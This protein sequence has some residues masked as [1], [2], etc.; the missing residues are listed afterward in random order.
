MKKLILF[1]IGLMAV[2]TPRVTAAV[3]ADFFVRPEATVLLPLTDTDTRLDMIEYFKAGAIPTRTFPEGSDASTLRI[4]ALND[5]SM[6]VASK[7]I[8]VDIALFVEPAKA[9][10]LV[11]ATTTF[12]VAGR[13]DSEISVFDAAL[14]PVTTLRVPVYTDWIVPEARKTAGRRLL[15]SVPFI[16]ARAVA[17]P[18]ALTVTFVNTTDLRQSDDP[19]IY[20]PSITYRLE[21]RR[22]K[23][24]KAA[25]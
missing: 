13:E 14:N 19:A 17:D 10:T 5:T 18:A 12:T 8:K 16:T 20:R 3:V 22:F 6:T 23:P 25:R 4:V 15:D 2:A 21:K 24:L 9:D 11:V 1:I 7:H